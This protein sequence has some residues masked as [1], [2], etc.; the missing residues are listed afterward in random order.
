VTLSTSQ[1][2]RM[3]SLLDEALPLDPV[4]RRIWL[5]ALSPEH[6]D[7]ARVLREA[8][9]PVDHGTAGLKALETLPKFASTDEASALA[10]GGL[11]LGTRVGPHAPWIEGHGCSVRLHVHGRC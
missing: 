5:E 7:L 11:Q 10:T 9:F 4:G 2:T 6:Q 3:S 1:M 8:L